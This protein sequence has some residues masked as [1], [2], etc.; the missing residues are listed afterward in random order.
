MSSMSSFSAAFNHQSRQM[1]MIMRLHYKDDHPVCIAFGNL[2]R[3]Q[4]V[5]VL[6]TA[7]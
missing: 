7:R 1:C 6:D 3:D 2:H 5:K 4:D